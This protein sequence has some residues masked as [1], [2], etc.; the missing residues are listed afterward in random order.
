LQ[1]RWSWLKTQT[2]ENPEPMNEE[3]FNEFIAHAQ[4]LCFIVPEFAGCTVGS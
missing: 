3:S 1:S 4:A 2:E